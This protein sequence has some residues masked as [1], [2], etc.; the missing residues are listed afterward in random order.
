MALI[1]YIE[2]GVDAATAACPSVTI[3]LAGDFNALDDTE[4]ATRSYR[5]PA[6]TRHQHSRP[7]LRQHAVL[8]HRQS[9]R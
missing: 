3:V 4:V 9:R 1:D 8:Q 7:R 5:R 6:D 2:D